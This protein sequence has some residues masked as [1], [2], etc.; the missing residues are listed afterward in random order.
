MHPIAV[1]FTANARRKIIGTAAVV[2]IVL[3][4]TGCTESPAIGSSICKV[5]ITD[6]NQETFHHAQEL[7]QGVS[8]QIEKYGRVGGKQGERFTLDQRTALLKTFKENLNDLDRAHAGYIVEAQYN[9]IHPDA[10]KMLM[11]YCLGGAKKLTAVETHAEGV[12]LISEYNAWVD[13][14]CP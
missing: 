11:D 5:T 13:E 6:A 4:L 10:V 8:A 9:Q 2:W 7:V 1:I 14:V 12:R 3:L